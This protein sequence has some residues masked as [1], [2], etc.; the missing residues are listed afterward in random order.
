MSKAQ[1]VP[2]AQ[3][4][5]AATPGSVVPGLHCMLPAVDSGAHGSGLSVSYRLVN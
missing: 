2:G 4:R 1:G 3:V 5:S